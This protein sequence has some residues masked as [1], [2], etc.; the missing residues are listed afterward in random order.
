MAFC[1]SVQKTPIYLHKSARPLSN[2]SFL[3]EQ[4]FSYLPQISLFLVKLENK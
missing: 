3:T 4:K 2:F 1:H